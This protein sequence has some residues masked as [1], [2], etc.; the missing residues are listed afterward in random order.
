M[1]LSD[2]KIRDIV[3]LKENIA[4]KIE[5][6]EREIELLRKN[7]DVLDS[8][9]GKASFTKAS[10]LHTS[11]AEPTQTV[12]ETHS[13]TTPDPTETIPITRGSSGEVI[14]NAYV[15]SEQVSIVINDSIML[16][17]D[18]S[19]FKSF[20][21]DRIIGEMRQKDAAE[22]SKGEIQT[23]SVIDVIVDRD[24]SNMRKITVKNYRLQSRVREIISTAGWSMTRMLDNM[25]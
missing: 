10:M 15:T 21:M 2:D 19:P 22:A 7:L 5:E 8:V 20:F 18:E 11:K 25:K 12:P 23:D 4:E 17:P 14:A 13:E 1:Q 24:G 6:H 9:I 3:E 16:N